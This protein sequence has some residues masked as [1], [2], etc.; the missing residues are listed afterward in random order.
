MNQVWLVGAP[1]PCPRRTHKRPMAMEGGAS[2]KEWWIAAEQSPT[3]EAANYHEPNAAWRHARRHCVDKDQ[4]TRESVNSGSDAEL[5]ESSDEDA[6]DIRVSE[7]ARLLGDQSGMKASRLSDPA[8][9]TG[10]K[11]M[12]R[13]QH[14]KQWMSGP[15][16]PV[17]FMGPMAHLIR[18]AKES[19]KPFY[20]ACPWTKKNVLAFYGLAPVVC[21]YP[22]SADGQRQAGGPVSAVPKSVKAAGKRAVDSGEHYLG[23]SWQPTSHKNRMMVRPSEKLTESVLHLAKDPQTVLMKTPMSVAKEELDKM[24]DYEFCGLLRLK[25]DGSCPPPVD[26]TTYEILCGECIVAALVYC[27]LVGTAYEVTWTLRCT[28]CGRTESVSTKCP[29]IELAEHIASHPW[30][31]AGRSKLTDHFQRLEHVLAALRMPRMPSASRR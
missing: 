26:A 23:A 27:K 10:V 7:C 15:D 9:G 30:K 5:S 20:E 22:W 24:P 13:W 6:P 16:V 25:S 12:S 11:P 18:D 31:N 4:S 28:A 19:M 29:A 3:A 1:F 21:D 14:L 8:F 17:N 2:A